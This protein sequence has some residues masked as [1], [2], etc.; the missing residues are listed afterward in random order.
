MGKSCDGVT[1]LNFFGYTVPRRFGTYAIPISIQSSYLRQFA[2][3]HG[4]NFVLPITEFYMPRNYTGLLKI[5]SSQEV[6]NIVCVSIFVFDG[7][8]Y[9]KSVCDRFLARSDIRVWCA[10]ENEVAS[11]SNT[12]CKL[13]NFL[14]LNR[15]SGL[16]AD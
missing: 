10:L 5:I 14:S 11:P 8:H 16:Y 2:A 13:Q 1:V 12:L 7:L 6:K 3:S 4:A 15:L 9:S